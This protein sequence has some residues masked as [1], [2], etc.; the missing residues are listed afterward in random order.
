LDQ[1][2]KKRTAGSLPQGRETGGQRRTVARGARKRRKTQKKKETENSPN[3]KGHLND[4]EENLKKRA[5]V[6]VPVVSIRSRGGRKPGLTGF[7]KK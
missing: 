1:P 4:L 7:K 5:E 2:K 3:D 6:Q